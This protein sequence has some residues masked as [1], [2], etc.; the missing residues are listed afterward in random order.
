[1]IEAWLSASDTMR[2]VSPVIVRDDAGVGGEPGLEGQ[3]R[4]RA[5]ELGQLRFELL[6]HRHRPGDR[7]D[8]AAADAELADGGE[9]RLAQAG[10]VGQARGSR[11][12][13][14]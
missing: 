12:M 6:V 5:L 11:S 7:P 3:D 9:G 14:G 13:T 4:R 2:S 1:M 8:R 10:M